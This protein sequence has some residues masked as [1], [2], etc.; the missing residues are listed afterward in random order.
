MSDVEFIFG[1]SFDPIHFGHLHIIDSL[2][3]LNSNWPIRILPCSVPAL[4]KQTC[5]SFQQRIEM[6]NLALN[7]YENV[8]VDQREA[9]RTG[10]SYSYDT[11]LE[12]AREHPK[13]RFVWVIGSDNLE[14][15][16][17]WHHA[18]QLA[19]YC[20][21]IV[22]NRPNSSVEQQQSQVLDLG[23][24]KAESYSQFAEVQSGLFYHYKITEK[25]TSST[26]IRENLRSSRTKSAVVS[27]G[28][29]NN[30]VE[31]KLIIGT[32]A[33][34]TKSVADGLAEHSQNIAF[35][36]WDNETLSKRIDVL[37]IET[38]V[39]VKDY[40]RNNSIYW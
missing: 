37:N 38:P 8:I 14:S 22:V 35:S 23:F 30:L 10:K 17:K 26:A 7:D 13:R 28:T 18:K 21:M 5:A 33:T 24:Q 31:Q 32:Q 6:I 20:H 27:D 4:K 39:A 15:I 1:G 12:L 29:Q 9:T 36:A 25:E 11:L 3:S 16:G 40:I 34:A 2:Q 19:S